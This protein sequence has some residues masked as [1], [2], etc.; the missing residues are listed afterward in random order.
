MIPRIV[1]CISI[2]AWR[3]VVGML[4]SLTCVAARSESSDAA[5]EPYTHPQAL[6]TIAAGRRLNLYCLGSGSPVV[7]LDAGLGNSIMAWRKVHAELAKTTTVCAYDR[8]GFGFSDPG[9]LPRTASQLVAELEAL[10]KAAH[11][12]RPYVLVGHSSASLNVRLYADRH[13]D[14]VV[15]MVLVDPSVEFQEQRFNAVSPGNE[16]KTAKDLSDARVCLAELRAGSL[17]PSTPHYSD[18]IDPPNP[19]LPDALNALQ[20]KRELT[21]AFQETALSE[22]ESLLDEGSRQVAAARRTYG[23][24]PLIVLTAGDNFKL[25]PDEPDASLDAERALWMIMHDELAALSARGVNRLINGAR[26]NIQS[27]KPDTV[28]EAV[29]QVVAAARERSNAQ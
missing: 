15:G 29:M 27:T 22:Y 3:V 17:I 24:L 16:A 21:V 10:F 2:T 25:D 9:P 7:I 26:H 14:R 1:A 20:L 12:P 18:C 19:S 13:L 11:L 6:V 5:F 23:S 8:A 4:M 28:I